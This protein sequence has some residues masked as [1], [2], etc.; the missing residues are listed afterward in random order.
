MVWSGSLRHL[1]GGA[2]LRWAVAGLVVLAMGLPLLR[3]RS[4]LAADGSEPRPR[5]ARFCRGDTSSGAPD[6]VILVGGDEPTFALWYAR[7][8]LRQRSDVTPI[9][10]HLY[11]FPWYQDQPLAASSR[12][13]SGCSLK[14]RCR[15][16]KVSWLKLHAAGRCTVPARWMA[17]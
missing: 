9:N 3:G 7:Y 17:S 11:G 8:G 15:R 2:S 10:V 16:W 5:C 1:P 12:A 14:G 6:A 13:G 4:P